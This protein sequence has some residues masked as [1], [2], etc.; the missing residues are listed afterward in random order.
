MSKIIDLPIYMEYF[1]M[2]ASGK[3]TI[4]I[5]VGY[6]FIKN[7]KV[8]DILKFRSRNQTCEMLVVRKTEYKTLEELM[9]IED[10]VRINH[11]RTRDQQIHDIN[12]IY[13]P[14]KQKLGLFVFEI[15]TPV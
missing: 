5:R 12:K 7:V 9:S 1:K 13:P 15:K 2:I 11:T 10:P 6:Y 4:E 3:K 8:G 14:E